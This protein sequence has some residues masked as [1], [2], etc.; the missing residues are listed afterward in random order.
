[1]IFDDTLTT[2]GLAIQVLVQQIDNRPIPGHWRE[3]QNIKN[4]IFGREVVAIE[5][6]PA[7]SNLLDTHNIYWMWIFPPDVL[8]KYIIM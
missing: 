1:M 3:M 4:E 6:Y 8:P 5:Y 2:K 7:E